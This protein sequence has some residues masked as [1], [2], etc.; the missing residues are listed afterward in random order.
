MRAGV[1]NLYRAPFH[2]L[3]RPNWGKVA[4]PVQP[5]TRVRWADRQP[6][7]ITPDGIAENRIAQ[8]LGGQRMRVFADLR[9]DGLKRERERISQVLARAAKMPPTSSAREW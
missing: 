2:K 7:L 1:R 3:A 5:A 9:I 4:L 6:A 8:D